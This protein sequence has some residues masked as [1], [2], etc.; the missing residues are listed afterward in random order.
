MLKMY[1]LK[2]NVLYSSNA[3]KIIFYFQ[4]FHVKMSADYSVVEHFGGCHCGAIRF[5]ATAS[6]KVKVY[7]CKY[8]I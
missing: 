3:L 1:M 7:V 6:S 8:D 5:T 4:I 2:I